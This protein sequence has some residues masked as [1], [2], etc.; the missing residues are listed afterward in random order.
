ME[1]VIIDHKN[2]TLSQHILLRQ[3]ALHGDVI[4]LA[5][6]TSGSTYVEPQ[7]LRHFTVD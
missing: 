4:R 3:P 5:R 7:R 6:V 1:L 2:D